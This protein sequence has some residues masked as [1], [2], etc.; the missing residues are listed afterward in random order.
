M[1]KILFAAFV[2]LLS[3]ALGYGLAE[4]RITGVCS[5]CHTMHYSQTP[6]PDEWSGAGGP[7]PL[8]LARGAGEGVLGCLGCHIGDN[9]DGTGY[10]Y[11][12]DSTKSD[13]AGGNFWYVSSAGGNDPTKGHNVLEF[14][15]INVDPNLGYTPPANTDG[16]INWGA[17]NP[18]TCSGTYGC[19]GDRNKSDPFEAI[20]GGHHNNYTKCDNSSYLTH[21]IGGSYR[22]LKGV[23][24]LEKDDWELVVTS[25][26][27]NVYKG[28]TT[29]EGTAKDPGSSGSISG[30]CGECHGSS[31]GGTGAFHSETGTGGPTSPWSRHPTDITLL[32]KGGEYEDYNNT[33]PGGGAG[34]YNPVAPL[35]SSITVPDQS[36]ANVVPGSDIVMCVSCHRAHGTNYP[37]ILRWSYDDTMTITGGSCLTCHTTKKIRE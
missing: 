16:D 32:D 22:F 26:N 21:P 18:L 20:K 3:I 13:L 2:G 7:F 15:N 24:G 19:H 37:D 6:W 1:R 25:D 17:D 4:A 9:D 31:D 30:L 35:G 27:H 29:Y 14:T 28:W 8:L 11:I 12:Y 10:P 36:D 33:T 34:P 5:G 23:F